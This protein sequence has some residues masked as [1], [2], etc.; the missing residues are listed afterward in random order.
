MKFPKLPKLPIDNPNLK[1]I[2]PFLLIALVMGGL[3][4]GLMQAYLMRERGA[5]AAERKQLRSQFPP[6]VDVLVAQRDLPIHTMVTEKDLGL[7]K[8]PPNFRQP[9]STANPADLIGLMTG[10]PIAK[11]EQVLTNKLRRPTEVQADSTTMTLSG[12]TPEGKRAVT[13]GTDALAGVGGFVRPGDKVDVLWTVKLPQAQGGETLTLMLI[14]NAS[15]L[16]VGDQMV[17]SRQG[18]TRENNQNYTVTLALSPEET[19]LLL[20]AREQGRIQLS[21]RSRTDAGQQVSV[22]ITNGRMLIDSIIGKNT[23]GEEPPKPQR[24]VEVF[25]GLERTVVAVND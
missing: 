1:Q 9:Y 7:M 5:L 19:S 16:A 2:I 25:K 20:Y 11:G 23:T 8:I 6:P 13:I 17:G 22:P 24:S 15:I 18:D 10:A 21:L 14:Q 12:L 4:I 3:S